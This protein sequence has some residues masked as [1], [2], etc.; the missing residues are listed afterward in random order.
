M[1]PDP[2]DTKD[3]HFGEAQYFLGI[4]D[5][6]AM[7][8]FNMYWLP[9]LF[10]LYDADT[11]TLTIKV[12]LNAADISYFDFRDLVIIKNREYR[13]NKIDYKPHDLS[14]VELILIP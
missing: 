9:Y 6:T 2:S 3:F 5:T 13:V 7:N 11:K 14:T 1:P 12:L 10:E 4:G 8:L